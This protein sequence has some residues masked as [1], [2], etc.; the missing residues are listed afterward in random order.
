MRNMRAALLA[1]TLLTLSMTVS[2][3]EYLGRLSSNPYS[4]DSISNP[5]G[6]GSPYRANGLL[7]P[8]SPYGSRFSNKSWTNPIATNPPVLVDDQGR[9]RGTLSSSP[10]DPNSVSN[11]LGQYGSPFS[12]N[13]IRN[14][15]G[16]GSPYRPDSPLNPY[17][18]GLIIL[19][20]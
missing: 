17:G 2:A 8:F 11:P 18:R 7:N 12:P 6:A 13:S 15:Y 19:G 10:F 3:E 1:V 14:P 4:P 5:Y 20:Q 16:A 9:F